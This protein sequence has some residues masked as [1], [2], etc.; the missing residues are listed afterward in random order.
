M[1]L[2]NVDGLPLAKLKENHV[3]IVLRKGQE[4]EKLAI[5]ENNP[6]FVD[7][8]KA[9]FFRD[10]NCFVFFHN[11]KSLFNERGE[12]NVNSDK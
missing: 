12:R 2:L 9:Y 6:I 10:K 11:N 3:V 1:D 7:D 4:F 8:Q 5:E